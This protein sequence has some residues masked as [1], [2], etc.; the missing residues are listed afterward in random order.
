YTPD[1]HIT[2]VDPLR[3]GHE[4]R[5]HPGEANVRAANVLVINKIDSATAEQ[6]AEIEASI[7]EL[8]PGAT[9]V[10]AHS[11]VTVDHP[12]AIKGK[13]VLV[14]EDGPTLTHGEMKYGAGV[15]A[16]RNA[17]AAEIVDPREHAVG[18]IRETFASY[19][20]I[21]TL[22]PAMGYGKQQMSDLA[23]TID[24]TPADVVVI[25]TPVDLRRVA[26]FSKPAVR[27]TY[28]LEEHGSPTLADVLAPLTR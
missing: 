2:V 25:A 23:A 27:V 16:A 17:G 19:P 6:V 20:E 26:E 10:R 1:V 13:R 14:V 28:D 11:P 8:N 9:V 24:A 18:S 22:L 7:R 12:D 15:V 21:G 5:Y 4:N 3:A